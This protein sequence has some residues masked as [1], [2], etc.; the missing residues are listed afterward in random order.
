MACLQPLPAAAV[1]SFWVLIYF[2]TAALPSVGYCRLLCHYVSYRHMS[3]LLSF[4]TLPRHL[5]FYWA[6]SPGFH[7]AVSH[8]H[9]LPAAL[10]AFL[11]MP[12]RLGLHTISLDGRT[13]TLAVA[14]IT[15]AACNIA[16]TTHRCPFW[17]LPLA[18][19][20]TL[21][22]IG[23]VACFVRDGAVFYLLC[24][25][26]RPTPSSLTFK[27]ATHNRLLCRR[28]SRHCRGGATAGHAHRFCSH[29]ALHFLHLPL[30]QRPS[31]A[32]TA[33]LGVGQ[34]NAAV[35]TRR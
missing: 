27:L 30:N 14:I 22:I 28:H 11:H 4:P 7:H 13:Q 2:T 20:F 5:P 3:A 15:T 21:A 16:P 34:H 25:A 26:S 8:Y 17:T 18:R 33:P 32:F 23:P 6:A 29:A 35:R 9:S 19:C 24:Y 12:Y 31:T 10:P 1:P